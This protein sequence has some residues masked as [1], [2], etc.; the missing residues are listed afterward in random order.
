MW[1]PSSFLL[2]LDKY[3]NTTVPR[4]DELGKRTELVIATGMEGIKRSTR[5]RCPLM[6]CSFH[7][8]CGSLWNLNC[9]SVRVHLVKRQWGMRQSYPCYHGWTHPLW[10]WSMISWAILSQTWG[11][12]GTGWSWVPSLKN[13][14][15]HCNALR[16][17]LSAGPQ[18]KRK[19]AQPV[20]PQRDIIGRKRNEHSTTCGHCQGVQR[21]CHIAID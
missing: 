10:C 18:V 3:I 8:H 1:F 19:H 20:M 4:R 13:M 14:K 16:E 5:L 15:T 21:A 17:G 9:A 11:H 12:E 7:L 2:Q 6:C